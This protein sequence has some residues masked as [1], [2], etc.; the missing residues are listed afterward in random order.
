M[1]GLVDVSALMALVQPAARTADPAGLV[2]GEGFAATL[3]LMADTEQG[4]GTIMKPASAADLISTDLLVGAVPNPDA[5]PAGGM[6][7]ALS[8]APTAATQNVMPES[9]PEDADLSTVDVD[10]MDV[11]LAAAS[12]VE[13]SPE[14]LPVQQAGETD[15]P[16]LVMALA[17]A[18]GQDG[19]PKTGRAGSETKQGQRELADTADLMPPAMTA[20]TKLH[21]LVQ[22]RQPEPQEKQVP[23]A[24]A[25]D[26]DL[27]PK[28]KRARTDAEAC[29]A[30]SEGHKAVGQE[31]AVALPAVTQAVATIAGGERA[32]PA[33]PYAQQQLHPSSRVQSK[34]PTLS[35]SERS[36]QPDFASAS[37]A[38]AG[39][40][41]GVAEARVVDATFADVVN[42]A[43]MPEV[44]SLSPVQH[45]PAAPPPVITHA[46]GPFPV[47]FQG[48][49][50]GVHHSAQPGSAAP[51]TG[52][53]GVV[54]ARAGQMGREMGVEIARRIKEGKSEIMLRLDPAE[55]G[56]VEVRMS[57][58]GEGRLRAVVS[59][60]NVMA[61]D[62]L[63]R[64]AG[65]LTRSLSDS[66]YRLDAQ[67][68]RFDARGG[69][70][71]QNL[72]QRHQQEA[73]SGHRAK[74]DMSDFANVE[75][76]PVY[77][78]LRES[79]RVDMMA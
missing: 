22:Q 36:A 41:K 14:L 49:S 43:A 27:V 28:G 40:D 64:D 46:G 57:F 5:N 32:I 76:E 62:I 61:L 10:D 72:W 29:E 38:F 2:N 77:R 75:D 30:P 48:A 34:S 67:S 20:P 1:C 24:L 25:D 15:A 70:Q 31:A 55:M 52:Q 21:A 3:D 37:G 45:S 78:H 35:A 58:D 9:L 17:P 50:G 66:G 11:S 16:N 4:L 26:G 68:F 33:Q 60:D 7:Q 63:R 18:S 73:G 44:G 51:A 59:A 6:M 65:D 39:L 12:L 54:S 74:S 42:K 71:G 56:R 53:A 19:R 47:S 79:G 23:S 69:D 13:D 8:S